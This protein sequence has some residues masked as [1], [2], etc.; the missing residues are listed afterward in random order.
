[1]VR[2][3][4]TPG[5]GGVTACTVPEIR[6]ALGSCGTNPAGTGPGVDGRPGMFTAGGNGGACMAMRGIGV[7]PGRGGGANPGTAPCGRGVAVAG[8]GG[9]EP[10]LPGANPGRGGGS[11]SLAGADEGDALLWFA[12]AAAFRASISAAAVCS[13]GGGATPESVCA[14][15]FL[16]ELAPTLPVPSLSRLKVPL[17]VAPPTISKSSARDGVP[18]GITRVINEASLGPVLAAA[19]AGSSTRSAAG[20]VKSPATVAPRASTASLVVVTETVAFRPAPGAPSCTRAGDDVALTGALGLVV[21]GSAIEGASRVE[22]TYR[23]RTPESC[24]G[25][26]SLQMKL[27]D[28]LEASGL[29]RI[30]RHVPR[31]SPATRVVRGPNPSPFAAETL[32]RHASKHSGV[33]RVASW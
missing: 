15:I 26:N 1:M 11:G 29:S 23:K 24:K 10:G 7:A 4:S 3:G 33:G 28:G 5:G 6:L 12:V 27:R 16:E 14:C 21:E 18:T 13:S 32:A 19:G 22:R 31:R 17:S 25:A 9:V 2:R 20:A 30:T 8:G